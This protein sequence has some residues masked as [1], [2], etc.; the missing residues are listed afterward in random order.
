M[1]SP[2]SQSPVSETK[3]NVNDIHEI[4]DNDTTDE[5]LKRTA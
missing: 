5:N 1:T 4:M 3:T 2:S